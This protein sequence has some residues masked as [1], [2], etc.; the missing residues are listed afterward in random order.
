[1]A[2][3]SGADY[4]GQQCHDDSQD[5]RR[6][7]PQAN[8]DARKG[9]RM[10]RSLLRPLSAAPVPCRAGQASSD[11]RL[12]GR[13]SLV[14]INIKRT[15]A[16]SF[17]RAGR[18]SSFPRTNT[19]GFRRYQLAVRACLPNTRQGRSAY[20]AATGTRCRTTSARPML[21]SACSALRSIHETLCDNSR[22]IATANA[23][24]RPARRGRAQPQPS[25]LGTPAALARSYCQSPRT[26][27]EPR[28]P[29]GQ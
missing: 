27:Q 19:S 29:C 14:L 25:G 17:P 23:A 4:L 3:I 16:F 22:Q 24:S 7:Y 13:Q 18:D 5:C 1:M 11:P 26:H 2:Y 6:P 12:N 8:P 21:L 15:A 28:F 10:F 9:S 20:P